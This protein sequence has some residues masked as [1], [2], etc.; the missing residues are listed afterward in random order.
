MLRTQ[1]PEARQLIVVAENWQ[2]PTDLLEEKLE[3][4]RSQPIGAAGLEEPVAR[5]LANRL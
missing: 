4:P 1:S 3:M 5:I 2:Y